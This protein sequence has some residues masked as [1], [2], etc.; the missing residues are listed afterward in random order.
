[1][2]FAIVSAG[3]GSRLKEEGIETPKPLVK[4]N[5]VPIIERLINIFISNNAESISIIVNNLYPEV[6]DFLQ[7]KKN[8]LH[9][10]LNIVCETTPSSLHSFYKLIPYLK[11]NKFCLTTVDTIFKEN[12]FKEYINSFVNDKVYDAYMAV[13]SFIDDEKPL[14]IKT[15]K[16]LEI[17]DFLDENT[18]DCSYISG[19]IYCFTPKVIEVIEHAYHSGVSRLRNFQRMLVTEELKLKAYPFSKIVDIDHAKDI[20]TARD[21]INNYE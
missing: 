1:M 8:E 9:I 11:Q 18:A 7:K 6:I 2:N 14:Y 16:A 5:D 21:F 10:P 19:G 13:T 17:L 4:L 12:E 15:N 20:E 3:E